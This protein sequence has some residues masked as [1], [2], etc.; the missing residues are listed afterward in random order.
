MLVNNLCEFLG[1]SQ[2]NLETKECRDCHRELPLEMFEPNKRLWDEKTQGP[3]MLRRPNCKDCRHKGK[4]KTVPSS[5]KKLYKK[6]SEFT[7]PI[8]KIHYSGK[9]SRPVLDHNYD[10]GE[11]RGWLCDCCNTAIGKLREDP[12]TFQRALEWIKK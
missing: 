7:C 6:P 9:T 10:T 11:V 8:C 1:E 12:D 2:P 3:R 5:I 4:K